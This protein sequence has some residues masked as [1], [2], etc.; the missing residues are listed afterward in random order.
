MLGGA[1]SKALLSVA[2]KRNEPGQSQDLFV[3]HGG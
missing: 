2:Y 3:G 1:G